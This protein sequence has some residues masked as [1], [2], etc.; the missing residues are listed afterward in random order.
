MAIAKVQDLATVN[1]NSA[2]T[3]ADFVLSGMTVGNVLIIRTAADNSGTNGAVRTITVSNQSGTPI[4]TG[5]DTA[6]QQNTDP[7]AASA[8]VTC[9]V[10]VASITA[11]SGT[12]RIT[13][14]GSVVQAGV[15]EE[16]S[17]VQG[18]TRVVGSP[19]GASGT[20]STNL[21]SCADASVASGNVAY[22][23]IATEGPST[24]TYTQD[25]DS[26]NGTWVSLTQA[27]TTNATADANQTTFGGYK[28]CSGVGAQ[29]YNPT[30]NNARDSAGII[31]EL[32]AAPIVEATLAGSLGAL[33]G[34]LTAGV[35]HVATLAAPLGTLVGAVAATVQSPVQ[36]VLA[37]PF[38]AVTA[39]LAATI[40]HDAV[41]AAPLGNVNAAASS[42]VTHGATL[43][44]PLG[45]LGG[46]ASAVVEHP[47]VA[48]GPLGAVDSSATATVEHPASVA[49]PL[50]SL[51]AGCAATVQHDPVLAAQFGALTASLEASL[52]H[53]V[54]LAAA[55]GALDASLAATVQHD[56]TPAA[57]LGGLTAS[58]TATVETPGGTV[59]AVLTAA[60]GDLVAAVVAV[61]VAR[62]ADPY[63]KRITHAASTAVTVRTG[64]YAVVSS[65]RFS[66]TYRESR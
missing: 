63:P 28:I 61:V 13:Y 66:T 27:G 8:G 16:W 57:V 24:D 17:G 54:I 50:G 59:E 5:T 51:T 15:A 19:V 42:T 23:A 41:L 35:Q 46:T 40:Q 52:D 14:S 56:A 38:G 2:V 29:T 47:A 53:S 45:S 49:A 64:P 18:V 31:V 10:V 36:A 62:V 43:A 9:N 7:G 21:A 32:A 6:Y 25:A 44:G 37:A 30:I 22:G 55:F 4:D 12:V 33:T 65:D 58:L 39:A 11:T 1:S 20:A 60:L 3:T 26:T 34:A 48:A